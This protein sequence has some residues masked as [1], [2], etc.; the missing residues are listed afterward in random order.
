MI[1]VFFSPSVRSFVGTYTIYPA[2]KQI[3]R[4]LYVNEF[5]CGN[6]DD[7]D[8]DAMSLQLLNLKK[9]NEHMNE[10]R[11]DKIIGILY[12]QKKCHYKIVWLWT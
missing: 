2:A 4:I 5:V 9:D 11:R 7:G 1:V 3:G 8:N 6:D 12:R 10:C